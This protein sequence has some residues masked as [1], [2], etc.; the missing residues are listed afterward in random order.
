[1]AASTRWTLRHPLNA[2]GAAFG[3]LRPLPMTTNPLDVPKMDLSRRAVWLLDEIVEKSGK[4]LLCELKETPW[5]Q[6]A[7]DRLEASGRLAKGVIARGSVQ[8][9]E[10]VVRT[11]HC[12]H[13]V[14]IR[15]PMHH[16]DLPCISGK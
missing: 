16:I 10:Y 13:A 2:D 15:L 6:N 1:M 12:A 5:T 7:A 8:S 3:T 4:P 14:S 9:L 11:E